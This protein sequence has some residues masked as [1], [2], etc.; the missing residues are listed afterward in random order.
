MFHQTVVAPLIDKHAVGLANLADLETR[1][2]ARFFGMDDQVEALI[3]AV[4]TGEPLL[5]IGP[6]GTA[7]SRLIRALCESTGLVEATE[8][9]HRQ[10][11]GYFEYLL[12]PFT[13]PSELF[14]YIDI[15]KLYD[16]ESPQA[17]RD[18]SN[19]IQRARVVFLDE[20]F[21][22]SSAILNSLLALMNEHIYHDRG[23]VKQ[24]ELE[25]LFA[26]TNLVPRNSE[27]RAVFDRFLLRSHVGNLDLDDYATAPQ[28]LGD[29]V[30]RGWRVTLEDQV[31]HGGHRDLYEEMQALNQSLKDATAR[32]ELIPVKDSPAFQNLVYII[33]LARDRDL[34]QFSNRR[35]V[36]MIRVMLIHSMYRKV[37]NQTDLF[38]IEFPDFEIVW[39][40]FLDITEP[41][42]DFDR[43]AMRNL[44]VKMPAGDGS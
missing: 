29:L 33:N 38:E 35:V 32:D 30:E 6:P 40:Y 5:F 14:G 10:I 28:Q 20:V 4:A 8:N 2:K 24:A 23:Q 16:R 41:L 42:S 19:S 12:T 31:P 34:C 3:L 26:A 9:G 27:L 44:P 22:G 36:K 21:N 18:E 25:C 11:R 43:D 13:E 15:A 17:V 37:K 39:K 1:L 7:K